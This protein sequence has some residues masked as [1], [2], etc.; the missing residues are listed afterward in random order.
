[1]K[2][3]HKPRAHDVNNSYF[4]TNHHSLDAPA[5]KLYFCHRCKFVKR[6]FNESNLF[7]KEP[8][9]WSILFRSLRFLCFKSFTTYWIIVLEI[10]AIQ[11][12]AYP[13]R[14]LAAYLFHILREVLQEEQLE[15][16]GDRTQAFLMTGVIY[17]HPASGGRIQ[18]STSR[19][20]N[21]DLQRN[22]TYT[23]FFLQVEFLWLKILPYPRKKCSSVSAY[24]SSA[25]YANMKWSSETDRLN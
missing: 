5:Q 25:L 4:N 14:K 21:F 17:I 22:R 20:F 18:N 24:L 7:I 15:M 10:T 12:P 6:N 11:N 9:H 16:R 13:K 8:V 1:M 2:S 19:I 3:C 23:T